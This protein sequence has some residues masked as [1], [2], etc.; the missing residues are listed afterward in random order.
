LDMARDDA[1]RYVEK[2]WTH[3]ILT[4]KYR[5]SQF[6]DLWKRDQP[7]R[8]TA[9]KR[10]PWMGLGGYPTPAAFPIGEYRHRFKLSDVNLCE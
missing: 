2:E 3:L 8:P 1:A 5:G 4:T 10:G 7:L 9:A 6:I